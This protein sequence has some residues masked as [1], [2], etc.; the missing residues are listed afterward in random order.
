MVVPLENRPRSGPYSGLN[1]RSAKRFMA[2]QFE[3]AGLPF[4]DEDAL[5]LLLGLTG[6]SRSDYVLRG[7]EF[8]TAEQFDALR[9]VA[10]RRLSGE[11]VDRILGWREFY[12]R[13]FSIE[14]VLSPRGDTEILLLAALDAVH[15]VAA[16]RLLDL[17]TGSGAL[18][19]SILAE[20]P[21]AHVIATD[22][23]ETA[24]RTAQHNAR[25]LGVDD[26][27]ELRASDWFDALD[28]HGLEDATGLDAVLS[29]PPYI[30]SEAMTALEPEVANHDPHG[31]LH[32]GVDG[33]DPYRTII[34]QASGRLRPGGW[35]GVEI[36]YDQG[37]A[38]REL[39][40]KA[41]YR[42]VRVLPDPGGLDRVVCGTV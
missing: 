41:G 32:G 38:V 2:R 16:P 19:L 31:A 12:G 42:D 34:P 39:F 25:S 18:A 28:A 6:M 29:N 40:T 4:A 13:R 9:A 27:L 22:R 26:R 7:T 5:D 1:H 17:G 20:R 15:N 10:D 24:L 33:L 36:G 30:T 23:D 11:P 37:R 21:D 14:G 3:A 35:L 8:I